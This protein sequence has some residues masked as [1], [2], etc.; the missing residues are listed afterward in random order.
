MVSAR[1]QAVV[2]FL[3]SISRRH[4][5]QQNDIR[6]NDI[7]HNDSQHNDGQHNEGQHNDSQHN[8]SE[9]NDSQHNDSQHNDSLHKDFSLKISHK[10]SKQ[11]S[12]Q[13][14]QHSV[15][16][17]AMLS[18]VFYWYGECCASVVMLS[19]IIRIVVAP[20][21]QYYPVKMV[22]YVVNRNTKIRKMS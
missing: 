19:V 12:T 13:K 15:S 16:S 14:K 9:H 2:A 5:T 18:H 1:R 10:K 3:T 17:V 4:D 6:H 11:F 21:N 8:D 22:F 7:Q 20:F